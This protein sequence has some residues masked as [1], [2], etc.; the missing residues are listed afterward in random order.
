[1]PESLDV[2]IVGAGLAGLT[3][4]RDLLAAGKSVLIFEARDRVGGKV[5]NAHLENGGITEV[6]A[7]FVGPTQDRVLA[8]ISNLGLKTFNTYTDGNNVLWENKTRVAYANGLP[9]I[10]NASL[11]EAGTAQIALDEMAASINASAPWAHPKAKEWDSVSFGSWLDTAT[12]SSSARFLLNAFASSVFGAENS[13]ALTPLRRTA[14]NAQ[15]QRVEGGTQLIPIKLSEHIGFQHILF[16][17][18][19]TSIT[20]TPSGYEIETNS[21]NKITAKEV[22]IAMSP[23]LSRKIKFIPPL[24]QARMELQQKTIMGATGKAIAVY[25]M[26]FWRTTLNGMVISDSGAVRVTFDNSPSN[27]SFGAIMGFIEANEMRRLDGK[28]EADVQKEVLVDYVNYFGEEARE[29]QEFVLMRWDNERYSMGA[30][31]AFFPPGVLTSVG[32]ALR[33]IVGG[34]HFAGTETAVYWTG[35]MDGAIRS[36]ERVAREILGL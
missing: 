31:V 36:G 17:S 23:P 1:M 16:N 21:A 18:P 9:P 30:P 19:V 5:L 32:E 28:S 12:P 25:K 33:E 22:V 4:A 29:I 3:A 14:N 27:G 20:Q 15:A 2:A 34:I 24:P 26:P 11:L 35:Y 13:R 10:N 7:E 8:L 6:G